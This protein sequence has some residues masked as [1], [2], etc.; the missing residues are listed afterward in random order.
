[1][2]SLA[3]LSSSID[4]VGVDPVFLR[5]AYVP[6]AVWSFFLVCGVCQSC[7]ID[8]SFVHPVHPVLMQGIQF[9]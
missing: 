5:C 1:M 3:G 8:V 2:L 7:I 9:V 4:P 6:V